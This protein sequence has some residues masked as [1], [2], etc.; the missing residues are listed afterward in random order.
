MSGKVALIPRGEIQLKTS[1]TWLLPPRPKPG[2]KPIQDTGD[3]PPSKR[4]A[5]NRAAQRA[6]RERRANRVAELEDH[7]MKLQREQSI[8]V[9]TLQSEIAQLKQKNAMLE[10]KLSS[11]Q[12][13]HQ[14]TLQQEIKVKREPSVS[15]DF[16]MPAVPLRKRKRDSSVEQGQSEE[17]EMEIDFT[18]YF[19]SKPS[20]PMFKP[21]PTFSRGFSGSGSMSNS[22]SSRSSTS[23]APATSRFNSIAVSNPAQLIKAVDTASINAEFDDCG[24]CSNDTPCVCRDAAMA[25]EIERKE[26]DLIQTLIRQ[27]QSDPNQMAQCSGNPGSCSKCQ[28]D[29]KMSKFCQTVA[30]NNKEL[31]SLAS[32]GLDKHYIPCSDAF[33]MIAKSVPGEM[34]GQ[35]AQGLNRSGMMVEVESVVSSIRQTNQGSGPATGR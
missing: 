17:P 20:P 5:Q 13:Q 18:D 2:R 30:S 33:R 27:V 32:L 19:N 26:K 21:M 15:M 12:Q 8:Q 6:F 10:K 22:S 16:S 31:P 14:Q 29:P 4:K 28:I 7:I 34:V 3:E 11:M 25:R 23:S 24:F 1:K 35:L 9:G